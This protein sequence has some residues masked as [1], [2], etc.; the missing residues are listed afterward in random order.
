MDKVIVGNDSLA[1]NQPVQTEQDGATQPINAGAIRKSTTSSILNALSN[2]SGTNFESV[3]SALSYI[4]RLSANTTNVGNAQPVAQPEVR[5]Q[6]SNGRVTTN[7][8]ADQF[9]RLQ[10]DLQQK[11]QA[12]RVK[13]LDSEIM[14]SMGDKFDTDLTDYA[15][16][17]VKSNIQ[18][19]NDGTYVI[20]NSKGQER[21]GNDG[22]PLTIQGLVNEIAQ[23]NPKLLKQSNLS[24]GSGLKPGNGMF[25]GAPNDSIPDY[26]KDPAAFNA[27]AVRNGLGRN[28]GLKATT[29]TATANFTGQKIL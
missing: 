17:K 2:A 21:Y 9:M 20:V 12:L 25:A 18:F 13:E 16:Q 24:S 27:W 6:Q 1:G 8:L 14:K 28:V 22:N 29:V 26:S 4:A 10:Q 7:D 15:L 23:G 3:E 11:D 19:N 5:Q